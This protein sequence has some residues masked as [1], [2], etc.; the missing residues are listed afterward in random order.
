MTKHYEL[1][2][3]E[4]INRTADMLLW[5]AE[6]FRMRDVEVGGVSLTSLR[7]ETV[8]R[9]HANIFLKECMDEGLNSVNCFGHLGEFHGYPIH[10]PEGVDVSELTNEVWDDLSFILEVGTDY[11]NTSV[12]M[13]NEYVIKKR[14]LALEKSGYKGNR[15]KGE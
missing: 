3:A 13:Y 14:E 9:H 7:W 10:V 5:A 6:R 1:I 2:N 8:S 11:W 15:I 4:N 12:S